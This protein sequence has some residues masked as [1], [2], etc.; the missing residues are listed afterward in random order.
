MRRIDFGQLAEESRLSPES[1]ALLAEAEIIK[2]EISQKQG[3]WLVHLKIGGLLPLEELNI[4][5]QG[6]GNK[7]ILPAKLKLL[8]YCPASDLSQQ[9]V[10][11]KSY[12]LEAV[13]EKSEVCRKWLEMSEVEIEAGRILIS[14]PNLLGVQVLK[15][16]KIPELIREYC[17]KHF[18]FSP[19][20]LLDIGHQPSLEEDL[21]DVQTILTQRIEA[22]AKEEKTDKEQE[23]KEQR[24][25]EKESPVLKGKP[26][27]A[28][29]VLIK[30]VLEEERNVVIQGQIFNIE[31]K[32]LK[33][34]RTVT[35][36]AI[37]DLTD[38]I[39]V[40]FFSE[41]KDEEQENSWLKEGKWLKVRGPV[42]YDP[43]CRELV[44]M[45]YDINIAEGIPERQD[46]ATEKRIELHAHTKMSAMDGVA[47]AADLVKT[48]A[49]WGHAAIAITDHGV[50]QAFPEAAEAA[51]K[52]GIKVIY[53]LE[54][55]LIDDGQPI[56]IG[57][58]NGPIAESDY[59]IF[60]LETTGLS[61]LTND[62]IE[63]GAVKIRAGQIQDRFHC[64]LKPSRPISEEISQL[65]GITNEMLA[66]ALEPEQ[67]L[68]DFLNFIRG[69]V[70]VAHNATFDAG[71]IRVKIEQYFSEKLTNPLLDTLSLARCLLTM[72][73]YKLDQLARH[74]EVD[75]EQHHRADC[76]AE[77]TALIFLKLLEL[78][79]EKGINEIQEINSLIK[80]INLDS[81]KSYHIIL[82]AQNKTGLKNLYK[83]VTLSHLHYYH[84]HP[85]IPKSQLIKHREG[86]IIGSACEAGELYRALLDGT[87]Q[88][89]LEE[90]AT[91]YDYLEIQPLGNNQFLLKENAVKNLEEL[92]RL[93]Q[94]IVRLGEK[95]QIPVVATGDVHFLNPEDEVY[96]RILM[97]GKGF[98]DADDQAPLYFK[99][100]EE[101]L[102]EFAYLGEEKAREVVIENPQ[103]IAESVEVFKPIPDE[104]YPPVLEGAEEQ[105]INMTY[106]TAKRIYGDPLPEIVQ[107]RI[108][109]ELNSIINNGFAV[110]YLIAHKL[111]RKSNDDG[112]LVGSRGSVGSSFV[113]TM[114]G[115]TEVNPLPPHYV[116]PQ[117]KKS[118]FILD[119][120]VGS[121]ADMPD[122][123]CPDCGCKYKK[124][125][126][127]I[128]FEVFLGFKGDKVPDI[129]LN[130]SGEYQPRAHKYTEE[131]F[132]QGNVFRAGTIGT[133]A[134]KTAFG[135]VK[136]YF[137]ERRIPKR[138]PELLRLV[139]GCTGVKR[140]TGQHPGG[141]MVV[142]RDCDVH[143]F[144]PLQ[145]P[146][147]D[148]K[149][150][151]ITT[152][153][154]YHSIS[155]RLVK[156]DIL[157][158]DD[159]TVIKMLEDLTGVD[160]KTIPLDEPKVLSLF[161]STEALG[162][163][164]EQIRSNV[165]TYGIPEFGT[166]FVRQMLEDTKPK[167]FSE[168]VRISGFSH[169]TDV[170]LNNAQ[171]LIKNGI[172]QL[173]EAISARDD[174]MIYLIYKGLEPSRAFKIMEGVRKGKGVKPEDEEEMRKHNVPEWY[175]ESCK[176][177]KYMFP[178]AHAVAY[179]MMAFRIAYFKVYYPEAFY[180]T[181]FTVRADE[182]DAELICQGPEVVR[183]TI[184]EIEAKGSDATQKEK[185]LQTI[186]ELALEMY[187]RGIKMRRISLEESEAKKFIITP[188]GLLPPFAG[189]QGVG[190][191]AAQ[192]IVEARREAPFVS[193]EDLRTRAR[194]TKTVIEVLDR[195]GCLRGLP[196]TSQLQ[197]FTMA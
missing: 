175:I 119:G 63:I 113:A 37:S 182:F 8:L 101:M 151:V 167:T 154:D 174:I 122:K 55:Y 73:N 65:T 172:C 103:K 53:G 126:H 133:I 35:T 160:A 62:I 74:F 111:V 36:F 110:L 39:L 164:P 95:L 52:Y 82:L 102:E 168:L 171:D 177:I 66:E 31:R 117:C 184:E 139:K 147:D 166:K 75:L 16:K 107:A 93:N 30:D 4:L 68:Q 72:K 6:L 44:V 78:V 144:T 83:L 128:P 15:D 150:G 50:V 64:F 180:A 48:A 152:H 163:T 148:K 159:P 43:F 81:L 194:L 145:Y 196:A 91:F 161:S 183:K 13:G 77:A 190:E 99:T 7:L 104:F 29:P 136:K 57:E 1:C 108:D 3:L 42:Q 146:A 191:A 80:N 71:F 85:R 17:L 47:S 141:V 142:P 131:L 132:G 157:G 193:I 121:G 189:L 11:L 51:G 153:F 94:E 118:E 155:S 76:D 169:G 23:N 49:R 135:F 97:A 120:S 86:L 22:I 18:E 170:W 124:D 25:E 40:K 69:A 14:M 197:L 2:V 158:H 61:P 123:N 24:K 138:N 12:L 125:G 88:E 185:N 127:D 112:Y 79:R 19:E 134:E 188:E 129:D 137:E 38:S 173:G 162:V 58:V 59:V 149:S 32:E 178:K 20:V 96:R 195:H 179:V 21:P 140:T 33:S 100:T 27:T 181:Y 187:M 109:K 67:G 9:S 92:Q 34:G 115:I 143:D 45:A 5:E 156:L 186:L 26:I 70:L 165:G 192:N 54:G 98:T 114:T 89:K 90:I 87:S 10:Q 60:D 28:T 41:K 105:I 46:Q 106:E 116:C 130:F 176:K 56:L 84:R